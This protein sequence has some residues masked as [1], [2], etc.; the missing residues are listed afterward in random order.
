MKPKNSKKSMKSTQVGRGGGFLEKI[1]TLG[2]V[3]I[4]SGTIQYLDVQITNLSFLCR[5]NSM[6]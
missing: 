5:Y 1:P 6:E 2:E 3:W 4:F